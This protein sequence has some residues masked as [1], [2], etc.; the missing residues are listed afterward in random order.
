MTRS[1]LAPAALLFLCWAMAA[2]PAF[3]QSD[4]AVTAAVQ[5]TTNAE[6]VRGHSSPQIAAH[7]DTGELV[8]VEADP[9]NE[10]ACVVHISVDDGRSWSRGGDP[11]QEPFTDCTLTA[12]YG[13][14]A[15]M[16]FASNGDLLVAFIASEPDAYLKYD[17]NCH[18]DEA[19]WVASAAADWALP[20]PALLAG[21]DVQ[22]VPRHVFLA[23]SSDTGRTWE[24]FRVF[25]APEDEV[26]P[27]TNKGPML[28]VDLSDPENV[29]VGWR[30]GDFVSSTEKVK[31]MV[32]ASTDGG[33]TFAEPVDL[34]DEHGGDYPSLAV[35]G[36]G[37]LHA[38]YWARNAPD[39]DFD[40]PRIRPIYYRQSS[41]NGQSYSESVA[42]DPGNQR[43]DRPPLVAADPNSE[44]VYVVWASDTE[45]RNSDDD[46]E[47]DTDALFLA[48]HD[49][50][51]T[52]QDR[53]V[54]NDDEGSGAD[55]HIPG[56]AIAPDGRV[57]V[58]WYDDR[59]SAGG[60][61]T[62]FQDVFGA[63]SF[64]Q[65]N[66]FTPNVRISDRSMDR[67]IGVWDNNI[68]S[69]HNVGVA[70]T[71]DAVYIA[72]QDSRNGTPD[73]QA[74]DVYMAKAAVLDAS[75]VAGRDN[76]QL[77]LGLA[78]GGGGALALAAIGL[79]FASRRLNQSPVGA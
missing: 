64:D 48:S 14:Y 12:E 40:E 57:D 18:P 72:W 39:V 50:G 55:Q 63:S 65:G 15:S 38:V 37:T 79:F 54:L 59:L 52:W 77:V 32:A 31:S 58:A 60:P 56:I 20:A 13:P 73:A 75:P 71:E 69:R 10:E 21:H 74:E 35:D 5:V 22:C 53:R 19:A 46:Y 11:M 17:M 66:S 34:S 4:F 27:A 26:D 41:D 62:G 30:Q 6:A 2:L 23:R 43:A 42:I 36:D 29:Y 78:L 1:R 7:P 16:A 9:M 28:A 3:A 45:P 47:G 44:A 61:E 25:E 8:I 67:R 49:G 24:T 51:G 68:Q 33:E 76:S 70:S